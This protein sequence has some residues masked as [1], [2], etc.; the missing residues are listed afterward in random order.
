MYFFYHTAGLNEMWRCFISVS[1]SLGYI[2]IKV[3]H[4]NINVALWLHLYLSVVGFL[5]CYMGVSPE[6]CLVSSLSHK[7]SNH[8]LC[9]YF[10]KDKNPCFNVDPLSQC[11][12]ATSDYRSQQIK[13]QIEMLFHL[14]HTNRGWTVFLVEHNI[15]SVLFC[16]TIRSSL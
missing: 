10:I 7:R 11:I 4:K 6:E 8:H 5:D 3:N 15:H 13:K 2:W 1:L 12:L 9:I 16:F 14:C